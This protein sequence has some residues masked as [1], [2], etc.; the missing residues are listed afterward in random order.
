MAKKMTGPR[1]L[2][3]NLLQEGIVVFLGRSGVW[4]RNLERA[5]P[6]HSDDEVA[7][8]E[9][10]GGRAAEANII[11]DPY[12]IEV[13][14]TG[15]SLA[16]VAFRER[17]RAKGPSINLEFQFPNQQTR[18]RRSVARRLRATSHVQI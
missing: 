6:A 8:L 17:M 14:K 15:S 4:E 10:L 1:V 2:T 9:A 16:P 13:E 18:N 5:Q 7:Q 11:V 12:L 3:A